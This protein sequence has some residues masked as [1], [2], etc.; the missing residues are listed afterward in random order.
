MPRVYRFY[1][2][3]NLVGCERSTTVV[4]PDDADE[5][6][7]EGAL[8]DWVSNEVEYGYVLQED[9]DPVNAEEDWS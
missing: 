7:L 3:V 1:V 8:Q 2:D 4:V 5:G 6:W 9:L